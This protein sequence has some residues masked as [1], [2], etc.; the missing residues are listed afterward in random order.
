MPQIR[1]FSNEVTSI[2]SMLLLHLKV[3]VN[4][5]Q[6]SNEVILSGR[7]L[8]TINLLR[9]PALVHNSPHT[10]IYAILSTLI[11]FPYR[12][13]DKNSKRKKAARNRILWKIEDIDDNIPLQV[14]SREILNCQYGKPPKPTKNPTVKTHRPKRGY[15]SKQQAVVT[16][17]VR[18]T[19]SYKNSNNL[20]RP[21]SKGF[22]GSNVTMCV[23][24]C[25]NTMISKA[26]STQTG[27][28]TR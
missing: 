10:S 24:K 22:T 6:V 8:W 3:Q 15:I 9:N 16:N 11:H 21:T 23:G 20:R 17:P 28:M 14:T 5:S 1:T 18:Q 26:L 27:L 13:D 2:S 4:F 7:G 19:N 12:A 25:W